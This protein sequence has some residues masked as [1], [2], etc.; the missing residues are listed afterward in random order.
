MKKWLKPEYLYKLFNII[1]PGFDPKTM[2]GAVDTQQKKDKQKVRKQ[3][4]KK[5]IKYKEE[6]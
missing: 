4:E 1:K 2:Q 6:G 3:G 5:G